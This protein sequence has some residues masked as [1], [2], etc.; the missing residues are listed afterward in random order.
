MATKNKTQA[1]QP[2]KSAR[3]EINRKRKLER[4]FKLQPNNKQVELALQNIHRRRKTP[5]NREWSHSWR[6]TAQIIKLFTGRFDRSIMSSN[7]TVSSAAL[8]KSNTTWLDAQA[9]SASSDRNFFSIAARIRAGS[10]A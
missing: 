10:T 8:Q 1:P 5:T 9:A 3:W 6:R 7:P 2:V 4:Q